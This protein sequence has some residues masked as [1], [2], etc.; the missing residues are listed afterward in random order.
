MKKFLAKFRK[1]AGFPFV[2]L[3]IMILFLGVTLGTAGSTKGM[4]TG[5]SF[6]LQNTADTNWSWVVFKVSAPKTKD[7]DGKE[8][9]TSVRLHDVYINIG[10]I[11]SKEETV[12][13][14]LQ[15]G[16]SSTKPENFFKLSAMKT[17]VFFNSS[18]VPQE[19]AEPMEETSK[20]TNYIHD[21]QYRWVAPFG[22]ENLAADSSYR[23]I[24]SS[25]YFRLI[26]PVVSKYE[27][28][29]VLINEIVFLGEV[30]DGKKG[31]GEYVVLPVE[32]ESRSYLPYE[33]Q[34]EGLQKAQALIDAQQM[35][36]L[37]S[38]SFYQYTPS[39]TKILM[40]LAEMR[41]A[42]VYVPFDSYDG[43]TTYNSLALNLTYF[44]TL[45]FGVSPFGVRFFNVLASFGILVVGFFFVR[46][47]FAGSDKAALSF[48][49]IYALAGATISLAH[50]ATPVMIGIFFLLASLSACYR[51]YA[52][53]MKKP[54]PT[55]TVPL[56]ISGI[57]GALAVLVNGAFIVPVAGVVALFVAGVIKQHKKDRVLL[58]EAI[59]V[60]EEEQAQGT[61]C[62]KGE[63]ESEG[64]K[65]VKKAAAAYRYDTSSAIT[66]F[67]CTLLFGI[68]VL[69]ILLVLPVAYAAN[70]IYNG[71]TATGNLFQ[72]AYQLFAA[73]FKG[74]A[75]GFTYFYPIF[76]G[77]G[78]SYAVTYGVMN[79]AATLL[80]L[81]GI[82]FAIYRIVVLAKNKVAFKEYM[83]VL[84]PCVGLVLSLI[85]ASFAGGAV[86][87]V[88]L[89]NLFAFMLVSGGGELYSLEGDKQAKTVFIVKIVALCLLAVCFALLAV[90]TF[91]IPLPASLMTK[92]I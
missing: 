61:Y 1:I 47:L 33:N 36:S 13:M 54:S 25:C 29:N 5:D 68:F 57:C 69:S 89:A 23:S 46:R 22:V 76:T 91:S 12:T 90:F 28:S 30:Q 27:N 9:T 56:L 62:A 48:A 83:S 72:I 75:S 64:S 35:P 15:W 3:L 18:Y 78:T 58:D 74:G 80:G 86:A 31:T 65:K 24:S 59:A 45:I 50:I 73:G 16:S 32:I 71:V 10:T 8:T 37:T 77:M 70:K 51:Y 2:F 82:G 44:G 7:K 63:E 55:S 42:E 41:M 52:V 81:V 43:D 26:F 85:T 79:F 11:Y 6:E 34:A 49:I 38:S 19:G 4:V 53:G 88:L 84:V 67:T 17:A 66:V 92:L 21:G 87:F 14:E 60:A 20:T 39:E 40:T